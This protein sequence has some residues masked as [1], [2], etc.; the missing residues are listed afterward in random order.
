MAIREVLV[1][2]AFRKIGI[3]SQL[4]HNR[5]TDLIGALNVLELCLVL[6]SPWK[7]RFRKLAVHPFASTRAEGSEDTS[8]N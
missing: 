6:N 4:L 7:W 5:K 2:V 8:V 3:L 1:D